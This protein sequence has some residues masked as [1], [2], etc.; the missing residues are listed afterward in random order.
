MFWL[1]DWMHIDDKL[2]SFY[3]YLVRRRHV[4]KSPN[5]WLIPQTKE[6]LVILKAALSAGNRQRT[7]GRRRAGLFR[8]VRVALSFLGG[9]YCIYL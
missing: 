2:D 9:R 5:F 3:N 1:L 6:M 8:P 7:R 4:Q